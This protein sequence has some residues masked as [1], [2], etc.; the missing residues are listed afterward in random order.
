[1]I[2]ETY[3]KNEF[4]SVHKIDNS[5]NRPKNKTDSKFD[6]I[7]FEIY[8]IH[9]FNLFK[10]NPFWKNNFYKIQLPKS[11]YGESTTSE[12]PLFD[13][14]NNLMHNKAKKINII[15]RLRV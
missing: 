4:Y 1:M 15:F 10:T 12:T 9:F 13:Y 14:F 7:I 8:G 6:N 3:R 5:F 2:S 11:T